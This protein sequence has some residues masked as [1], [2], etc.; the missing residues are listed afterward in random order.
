MLLSPAT[1]IKQ[2]KKRKKQQIFFAVLKM[3]VYTWCVSPNDITYLL[4]VYMYGYNMEKFKLKVLC[5]DVCH[6]RIPLFGCRFSSS[7]YNRLGF[8]WLLHL[9]LVN[10]VIFV[11]GCIS[12]VVG[13]VTVAPHKMFHFAKALQLATRKTATWR[14]LCPLVAVSRT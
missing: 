10:V 9:V 3:Q 11:V 4:L 5:H 6:F 1:K 13:F 7:I 2:K 12:F 14:W 8:S